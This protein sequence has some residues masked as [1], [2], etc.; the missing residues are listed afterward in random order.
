MEENIA[1][2]G[3]QQKPELVEKTTLSPDVGTKREP[4]TDSYEPGLALDLLEQE[5]GVVHKCVI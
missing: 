1:M 5:T 3:D 4:I 2:L